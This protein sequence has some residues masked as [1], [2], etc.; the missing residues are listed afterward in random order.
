MEGTSKPWDI[1]CQIALPSATENE[2]GE[3]DAEM[4]IRNGCYCVSEGAN[5][6]STIEAVKLFLSEKILFGPGKAAN[7]GGVATSGL[8]MSQN[9]MRLSWTREE[10]DKRLRQIM[11]QIHQACVKHG[12]EDGYVN[13]VKGANIAGFIK[14]ANAML[15]QGVM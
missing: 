5:M 1:P 4:L 2:I 10:V 8:E 15:D 13:Y 3:K 6:P 9:S 12:K 7:A 11:S 14:V